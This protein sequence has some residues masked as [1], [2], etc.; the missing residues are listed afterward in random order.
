MIECADTEREEVA[1]VA[2]PKLK[3][4]VPSVFVPSLKITEPVGV[5]APGDTALTVA[6]KVTD[7]PDTDGLADEA[8][9]VV[10]LAWFTVCVSAEDV[11]SLP[12][13]LVLPPYTAVIVCAATE[14]AA[15]AKVAC[16]ALRALLPSVLV[17]SENV[18]VPVGVPLP[19][20]TALTVAVNVT[21]C[22]AADGFTDEATVVVLVA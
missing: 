22:P 11:L 16:P 10:V 4:P 9:A 13:K 15:V 8:T 19:G 7:C 12:I 18:T 17:P 6:V 2:W 14:S 20:N 21:D 1:K 3:L 5:P